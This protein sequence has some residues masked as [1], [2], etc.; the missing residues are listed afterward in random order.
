MTDPD[1]DDLLGPEMPQPCITR[2]PF[3]LPVLTRSIG[4]FH[5]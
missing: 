1:I 2:E 4:D 5:A 3:T